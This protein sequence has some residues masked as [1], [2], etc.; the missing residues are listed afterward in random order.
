MQVISLGYKGSRMRMT[1]LVPRKVDGWKDL[2]ASL[3]PELLKSL[4]A[5]LPE[6]STIKLHLPRFAAK[7]RLDVI[8]ALM[9]LGVKKPFSD[10]DFS[11]MGPGAMAVSKAIQ[12]AVVEVNEEGTVAAAATAVAVSRSIPRAKVVMVDRPFLFTISDSRTGAILFLGQ[13]VEPE[14]A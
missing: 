8:P 4:H 12:E 10:G 7:S 13:V 2:R 6:T 9:A 14:K 11:A 1:L 5:G 3:D